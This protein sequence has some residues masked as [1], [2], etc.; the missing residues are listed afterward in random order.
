M[1][2]RDIEGAT[3]S[4]TMLA[5]ILGI[6]IAG[7]LIGYLIPVG[8]NAFYEGQDRAQN[9]YYSYSYSENYTQNDVTIDYDT[10]FEMDD[11]MNGDNISVLITTD[12]IEVDFWNSTS[13][14]FENINT[15]SDGIDMNETEEFPVN[16]ST[17]SDYSG[18]YGHLVIQVHETNDTDDDGVPNSYEVDLVLTT[19]F[20][21]TWHE[22]WDSDTASIYGIL[23]IFLIITPLIALASYAMK[24]S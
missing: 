16:L 7:L 13:S 1:L 8:M 6:V 5:T 19:N 10:E 24:A 17:G 9:G 20:E 12:K 3:L 18:D 2:R 23:G 22:P 11:G 15:T 4:S 14:A 21:Q